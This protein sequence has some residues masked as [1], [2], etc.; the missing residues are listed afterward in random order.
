M[1]VNLEF[2][3]RLNSYLKAKE[4][5]EQ[6]GAFP[7]GVLLQKD[8]YFKTEKG[9]LKLREIKGDESELIFY[10]RSEN[11]N[12]RWSNYFRLPVSDSELAVT[13]LS[14]SNNIINIVKKMRELFLYKNCRIHLDEVEQIG[15]FLE[16]E[17]IHSDSEEESK[18]Y[19]DYLIKKFQSCL[20]NSIQGSYSDMMLNKL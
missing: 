11:S 13:I 12:E 4:I 7:S 18:K 6:I 15:T 8:T 20:G 5:L 9:R 16:F 10:E 3:A 19:M 17:I 2:K 14:K 1:P